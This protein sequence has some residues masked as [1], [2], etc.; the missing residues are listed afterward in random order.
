MKRKEYFTQLQKNSHPPSSVD[1]T[2]VWLGPG[3]EISKGTPLG[4]VRGYS[5]AVQPF[6]SPKMH[7]LLQHAAPG[8]GFT[9][10]RLCLGGQKQ[11]GLPLD[12]CPSDTRAR[13]GCAAGSTRFY[14]GCQVVVWV[15]LACCWLWVPGTLWWWHCWD[16]NLLLGVGPG[17]EARLCAH[18]LLCSSIQCMKIHLR[19]ALF[20]LCLYYTCSKTRFFE[21][22]SVLR[23]AERAPRQL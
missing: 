11:P 2:Q 15:S 8:L 16:P 23:D 9:R 3:G 4:L 19:R 22:T 21:G 20:C 1:V 7:P 6:S 18:S 5:R 17:A 13:G 14:L 10:L 12:I